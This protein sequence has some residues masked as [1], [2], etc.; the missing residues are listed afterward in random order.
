MT[1]ELEELSDRFRQFAVRECKDSSPL[2]A[3]LSNCI[4]ATP[5]LLSISPAGNGAVVITGAEGLVATHP[6]F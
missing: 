4:A 1:S 3:Q 6:A 5:E 2:Y